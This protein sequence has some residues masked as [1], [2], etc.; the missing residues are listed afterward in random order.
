M[1]FVSGPSRPCHTGGPDGPK[2]PARSG[3]RLV[4]HIVFGPV[5]I[6]SPGR[7]VRAI[8]LGPMA[9]DPDYQRTGIGRQLVEQGLRTCRKAGYKV[10]VVLG[11]PSYYPKFGFVLARTHGI[12][13]EH[14]VPGDPFMVM[15]LQAGALAGVRGTGPLP[16]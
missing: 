14:E 16:A 9:V 3:E 1:P 11:H 13:W 2:D 12:H 6:D 15:E 7:E 10:A 8:G 4:G 5:E